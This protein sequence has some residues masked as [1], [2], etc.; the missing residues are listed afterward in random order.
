[1]SFFL[2]VQGE[3][4]GIKF[5]CVLLVPARQN[6]FLSHNGNFAT[7]PPKRTQGSYL[8]IVIFKTG[9]NTYRHTHMTLHQQYTANCRLSKCSLNVLK[10]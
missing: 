1:M 10:I 9:A 3:K 8:R 4:F 6:R 7:L 5:C 2:V